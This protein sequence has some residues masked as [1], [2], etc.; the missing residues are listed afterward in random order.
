M[1]SG[2]EKN[3]WRV[4]GSQNKIIKISVVSLDLFDH[5]SLICY[6]EIS[7]SSMKR[8]VLPHKGGWGSTSLMYQRSNPLDYA[9][10][11]TLIQND[12]LFWSGLFA[13]CKC[14]PGQDCFSQ[15]KLRTKYTEIPIAMNQI[16]GWVL[17]NK[18]GWIRY[19]LQ[20]CWYQ[21][22]LK[23]RARWHHEGGYESIQQQ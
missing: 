20:W 5:C 18:N 7:L 11:C 12:D 4:N 22:G 8:F 10:F 2:Y 17:C 21:F 13:I 6:N 15:T 23:E 3:L 16:I 19:Q 1:K 14:Y 9:S